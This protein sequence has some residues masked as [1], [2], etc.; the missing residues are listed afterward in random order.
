M[1]T[2][3][4]RIPKVF[5]SYSWTSPEYEEKVL[6]LARRLKTDGI[7]VMID[8]WMLKPGNDNI[9]FMEKCVKDTS[10]DYV[11][12]LLDKG[13]TEKANK[14]EGG[15]GVETQII[16]KEVYEDVDQR[17]FIPIIFDRNENG[18]IDVPIYLRT[19]FYF[20]LTR[21]DVELQYVNLVKTIYNK[22]VYIEP[23][24]GPPPTWLEES[25]ND[26][27]L[28]FSINQNKNE[29]ET[30][31][32]LLCNIKGSK[33]GERITDV[34]KVKIASNDIEIYNKTIQYRNLLVDIFFNS[35]KNENFLDNVLD[36]FN[37]L[38]KW[39]FKKQGY[40]KEIW[41]LFMHESFIYLIAVLQI[42]RCYKEIFILI[43]KTYFLNRDGQTAE[44]NSNDYFYNT[45]DGIL[46]TAV[47]IADDKNYYTGVG[48]LWIKNVYEPKISKAQLVA[49]DL[50]I[51]NLSIVLLDENTQWYW[52][53]ILYIYGSPYNNNELLFKE[54]CFKLKSK[55]EYSKMI[56]LFGGISSENIKIKFRKMQKIK[57]DPND[58]YRYSE[59]FERA[60]L[61]LDY[62]K[63]DEIASLN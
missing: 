27:V 20:D 10:I 58:R 2:K 46:N 38:K 39:I 41:S 49:A 34:D 4:F 12:I 35:C 17:K 44:C 5:I 61:I 31:N 26:V 7:D 13:Y 60:Y 48:N 40:E 32:E 18:E 15:V 24:L 62:I 36:F 50:L 19:R 1:E 45:C 6:N 3:E 16:S 37:N 52:F 22:P 57:A 55:Y 59:A 42:K 25:T 9:N 54:F 53:P 28:K 23:K 8:K 29:E 30:L 14:R 63:V 56:D 33:F 43:T 11:L 47:T 51:Y 21:D